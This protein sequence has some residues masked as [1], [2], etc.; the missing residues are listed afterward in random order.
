MTVPTDG[1]ALRRVTLHG[2]VRDPLLVRQRLE[3]ALATL[4]WTPP[5]LPRRALLLVR[6]L[7]ATGQRTP[8]LRR[9][10]A[11]SLRVQAREAR[12]PWVDGAAGS[13]GA[14]WFAD[15]DEL[16]ACLLREWLR[17]RAQEPWWYRA[18]LGDE[19]L[20]RW[21]ARRVTGHGDRLLAV[22][23]QLASIGLATAWIARLD[24]ATADA[25]VRAIA[26]DHAAPAIASA[27][28]AAT[29]QGASS[30][31][32]GPRMRASAAAVALRRLV[33]TVPELNILPPAPAGAR[34]MVVALVAAR[35]PG[36]LRSDGFAHALSDGRLGVVRASAT[37]IGV[38]TRGHVDVVDDEPETGDRPGTV[39]LRIEE[40][41]KRHGSDA[42]ASDAMSRRASTPHRPP[43]RDLA[44]RVP[45]A[46]FD[47]V[48]DAPKGR[49]DAGTPPSSRAP[50]REPGTNPRAVRRGQRAAPPI[51]HD[52]RDTSDDAP[53]STPRPAATADAGPRPPALAAWPD[54]RPIDTSFGGLFYLLNAALG[55]GLYGD[56]T[57]PDPSGIALSPWTL[58]AIAGD[59]WFGEEFAR[60]AL[61]PW[62]ARVGGTRPDDHAP[63]RVARPRT[64]AVADAAL[65]AWGE[66]SEVRYRASARR[67]RLVHPAGFVLFDGPRSRATAAAQAAALCRERVLLASAVVS[68]ERH[69]PRQPGDCW[70]QWLLPLMRARLARALGVAD[71]QALLDQVCRGEARVTSRPAWVD[72]TLSLSA[73][74]LAI[75]LAGLDRDPGWIPAA[76]RDVRFHFE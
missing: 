31:T 44:A 59:A 12:R 58:L 19:P 74:P 35:D 24:D 63:P 14:V 2:P 64:W 21:L 3:R 60:D 51:G 49:H 38:A 43:A 5:G 52:M 1:A 70:H 36:L 61:A 15:D 30:R 7:V 42:P 9:C 67:L 17:G 48:A 6:R 62:L 66:V 8:A 56:F 75:R 45:E 71:D 46:T 32:R 47:D 20:S 37:E 57:A 50:A 54:A 27:L 16:A 55:L 11:E 68:V 65:Q 18:A 4:D 73:L 72:V 23:A 28:D 13:G 10:I 53:P 69:A 29:G 34:L 25:A 33:T 22:I 40:A 26:R 41:S 76:G 39:P